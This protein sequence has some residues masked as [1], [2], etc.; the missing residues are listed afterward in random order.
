[1]GETAPKVSKGRSQTSSVFIAL[2]LLPQE[3]N[4]CAAIK[5]NYGNVHCEGVKGAIADF[6]CFHCP[7]V[8]PAGAKPLRHRQAVP[9]KQNYAAMP[10]IVF[11]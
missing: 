4:P 7:L 9:E 2:W 3:R 1:M 11:L 10:R 6:V 5:I 8:A